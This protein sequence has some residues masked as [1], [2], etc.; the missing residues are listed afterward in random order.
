MQEMWEVI[1]L[2]KSAK[3]YSIKRNYTNARNAGK[4]LLGEKH[5]ENIQL[6]KNVESIMEKT[7]TM[8][9]N[10]TNDSIAFIEEHE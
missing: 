2:E 8:H 10:V 6:C 5:N 1:C 4:Y 9:E 7:K 3:E